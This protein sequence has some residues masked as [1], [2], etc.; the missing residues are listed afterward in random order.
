MHNFSN[1]DIQFMRRALALAKLGLTSVKPNPMVGCVIVYNA[2]IIGE[3]YHQKYGSEHAEV[4]AINNV[5]D[6][7]LLADSTVYVTL[8]PCIHQGKT[9]PCVDL[10][11]EK[12][13]KK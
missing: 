3:G 11:I 1:L 7:S 5:K 6:H 4:N 8:E 13:I 9:P 12:N 10:L 2:N